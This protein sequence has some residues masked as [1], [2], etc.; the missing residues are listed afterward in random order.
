N[1]AASPAAPLRAGALRAAGDSV[2]IPVVVVAPAARVIVPVIILIVIAP[3]VVE[4]IVVDAAGPAVVDARGARAARVVHVLGL[5]A[6]AGDVYGLAVGCGGRPHR[7]R[8]A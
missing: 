8:R 5:I 4:A 2:V 7:L 1:G 3:V 6:R